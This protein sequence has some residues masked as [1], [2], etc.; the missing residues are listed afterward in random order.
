MVWNDFFNMIHLLQQLFSKMKSTIVF[1]FKSEDQD[2]LLNKFNAFLEFF[3]KCHSTIV[4]HVFGL[5]E[6][7][8]PI[9]S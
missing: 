4:D 1:L 6:V 8:E 3:S 2:V 7:K 5:F 9:I